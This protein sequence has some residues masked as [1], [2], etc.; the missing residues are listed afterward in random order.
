MEQTEWPYQ[1]LEDL[2][3][4]GIKKGMVPPPHI[5]SSTTAE[6]GEVSKERR[7]T[8]VAVVTRKFGHNA[9]P[10]FKPDW[11]AQPSL[12]SDSYKPRAPDRFRK[13]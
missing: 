10:N 6:G 12:A 5:P 8:T 4:V 2:V 13:V 9:E 1:V 11:L 7:N 3:E